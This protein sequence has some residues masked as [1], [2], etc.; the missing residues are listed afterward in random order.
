M[1]MR[2]CAG[3]RMEL[4][5]E[6]G[7]KGKER[8]RKATRIRVWICIP[9]CRTSLVSLPP[10]TN[11]N[12]PSLL[13]HLMLRHGLLSPHSKLLPGS[14][15]RSGTPHAP[16][17]V[18]GRPGSILSLASNASMTNASIMT[19]SGIIKDER[20]TPTRRVRHRDGRLLAGGIGLTTGLGWSDR[21]V[22]WLVFWFWFWFLSWTLACERE[23]GF[24]V[25]GV[26]RGGRYFTGWLGLCGWGDFSRRAGFYAR[27]PGTGMAC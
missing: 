3:G 16:Y 7:R 17:G 26:F 19:K 5:G 25:G 6:V 27:G 8:T 12:S 24:F 22:V 10:P 23:G 4:G 14:A 15:S 20:D 2:R 1:I 11:T 13:R 21:W 9:H 18:D